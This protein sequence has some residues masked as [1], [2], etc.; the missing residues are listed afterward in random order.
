MKIEI[1]NWR[2]Y[3]P[4]GDVKKPSWF[5]L[6]HDLFE[7]PDF[8]DFTPSELLAWIYLL[9]YASKKNSGEI[10]VS[11]AHLERVGRIK[12]K[13]FR[14]AVKKLEAL[15]CIRVLDTSPLRVRNAQDTP[16]NATNERDERDERDERTI[17]PD[18]DFDSLYKKY[19]RKDGKTKGIAAC[20]VQIK[21]PEDF[22]ALSLAVDR[23][24]EH[25]KLTKTETR[26]IKHFSTF[27]STWRDWLEPE[28]GRF[29]AAPNALDWG[30]VFG[31]K[32][33]AV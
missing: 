25:C 17:S 2:T 5:R 7:D 15:Q 20:R 24:A 16:T 31:D 30:K 4:R 26:F 3:N 18:F 9:C 22:A 12:E 13:D 10:F 8:Y 32:K 29:Q 11:V 21:S 19:P 6:S 28:T 33:N 27:M 23:Y 1:K 14:G